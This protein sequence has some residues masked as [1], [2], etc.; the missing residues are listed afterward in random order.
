VDGLL[1]ENIG[2][3][4]SYTAMQCRRPSLHIGVPSTLFHKSFACSFCLVQRIRT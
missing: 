4:L 1:V 2:K 3:R